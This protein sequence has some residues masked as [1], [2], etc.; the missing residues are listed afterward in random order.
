M[1][2]RQG[3]S[4]R[5]SDQNQTFDSASCQHGIITFRHSDSQ[6]YGSGASW[7]IGSDQSSTTILA[8]GKLMYSEGIYSKPS[9]GTG[10]GTRKDSNWD[11]AYGWGDHADAGYLTSLNLVANATNLN[12]SDDRDMAPE[13]LGYTNDLRIFFSTKEGLEAGSGTGT[14]YQDVLYLNSY[15]DSSGGDANIL[16]FDKSE[17]KI[18]H[19]QADQAATNWGTAKTIAYTSDIPTNNNQLSNGAGYLTSLPSHN[20][21]DRYYTETESTSRFTRKFTFEPGAGA[22]NRRYMKLFTVAD[23]DASVVGKLSSAGDYGDSD[24]ATYEIQIATRN[25]ISFDIYQLSTD[26]V[27]DDYEFFYKTAGSTYEIWCKFGDYNKSQTFTR[28]SDYGTVTYNFDSS[29]QTAPSGLTSVTKSNIYHEGH[30]PTYSELGTMAYSNLTGTPTIPTDFVSAAN[31]GTFSGAV[32][33]TQFKLNNNVTNTNADSFFVYT[34]G[35]STTYGMTLWNTSG[36]SGE[37]ATMIYGPN[38]SNRRISFGKANSNFG[39]NHAG[40]DELAWLD[41]DNGNY[42]TDGN[43]YPSEQTTHYV[44]SGRIQNWQ[45]AYN[46]GDHGS[47][48]YLTSLP[49]HNHDDRYYTESEMQTF[50]DRGYIENHNASNLAVG[51]YTIA[52]NT[53][54][55]ALGEFQIWDTASSDH[56][57]VIFSAAHHFGVDN[58][59]D[60]TILNQSR[61]SGTN[62]RYIRIKEHSTYDGAALQVY[63]DGTS[64]SVYV[65]IVGGN[66]QMSGWVIK[67]WIPDATDPGDLSSYS[68]FTEK[69]KVDLDV[70]VNGGMLTT[71]EIY[72]GGQTSQYKAFH[73]GNFTNNSSNWNTAYGWG[74][75]ASAGYLTSFD[76]TDQT[77]SKYL[78]SNAADTATHRVVFSGCDT[79]NHDTIAT[80]AGSQGSI[81]IFNNGSGNDAFMTFHVGGDYACYFGLDGGTNKLSVGGWSMGANSYEIYHSGNK[82]SLATLG[83]TGATNANYITNNNQLTNG[84]GYI[85]SSSLSGY[86]TTSS[87]VD[88]ANGLA[89][90]GYGTDEMTFQQLSSSFAGYTGGWANYFI[91]NHGNGSNYYNTVHIMP[92]LLYTSPSPRD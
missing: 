85:T 64:N 53:G 26:A 18:Y 50:F 20:H 33:G 19:Y 6:S 75:H 23:F 73:A 77:D 72:A 21:D 67:D 39:T 38:Q 5:V 60:I 17:M 36:T 40:I 27:S 59:N 46:W 3:V 7:R 62:F 29:T 1:Y 79:N 81:E 86:A 55:R 66:A 37:W 22:G 78:R 16:A 49:S 83:F 45:T 28:F 2:K 51:W 90:V 82:P 58:S 52:T 80:G 88:K 65:A 15:S 84:A 43:I 8:D 56:Q 61:Y 91:G 30:K 68:S 69:T 48:G 35:G 32:T 31:G 11:T 41:L 13:D 4:I 9:S 14:N 70:T 63:I 74:N 25:N 76:I 57:T 71:G 10:A 44:S 42:F 12:A 34:D 92:C 89:E 47:A 87:T 54:D 24:R